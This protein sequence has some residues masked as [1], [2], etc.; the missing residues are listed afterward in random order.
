MV[1]SATIGDYA[2]AVCT[3]NSYSSSRLVGLVC[4][5]YTMSDYYKPPGADPV[6]TLGMLCENT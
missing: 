4:S 5:V 3:A 1:L 2:A 6:H